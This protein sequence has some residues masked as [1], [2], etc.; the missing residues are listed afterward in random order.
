MTLQPAI[1]N[2]LQTATAKALAT[3]GLT[4]LNVVPVSV[5]QVRNKKKYISIIFS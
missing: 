4:G 1:R 5:L 2:F 3:Y